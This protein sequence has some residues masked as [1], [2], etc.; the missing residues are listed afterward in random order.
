VTDAT[1]TLDATPAAPDFAGPSA[2]RSAASPR[3]AVWTGVGSG[4]A[5]FVFLLFG[6]TR[7]YDI[8]DSLTIGVFVA[9][10]SISDAFTQAYVLN[11]HV[12]FSFLEHLVYT[13]TG[14]QSEPV[15]RM[16]PIVFAAVSVGVLASLLSRRWGVVA[17]VSGAVL[18]ATNPTFADV[19]SQVRGYSLLMLCTIVST[20]LVIR[21]VRQGGAST[22]I[23][24]VYALVIA[25]GVAT[26][27]YMLV[28][29][30]IHGL[31]TLADRRVTRSWIVPWLGGIV[32]G[33]AA[34]VRVWRPMRQTA[35]ELGRNFRPVFPRDLGYA[36]LGG[37][38]LAVILVAILVLPPLW[39][40]RRDRLVQL[41]ALA[42]LLA[43]G[44]IWIIGPF[45]LYPRFFLWLL[46]LTA[47]GAAAA[48]GRRPLLVLL[49]GAIVV[50]QLFSSWP[51]LTQD[52][53]ASATVARV[54]DRVDQAG[55]RPCT[56]D[57]FASI[58]LLGYRNEF[59]L[60]STRGQMGHCTVA[61]LLGAAPHS[62]LARDANATF[63]YRTVLKARRNGTLWS[64]V[65]PRC[66]LRSPPPA[67]AACVVVPDPDPAPG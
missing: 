45:D 15:M 67:D 62:K 44:G 53:I 21:A 48:V 51:R 49:V 2:R 43:V 36:L 47:L 18:M 5:T 17:A 20:A 6:A 28:V 66:W 23:R 33:S 64:T 27:L 25:V 19:G 56:I 10:P 46:P 50:V 39:N 42:V 8:D 11:N 34:Y 1:V 54:F 30:A 65:P 60:A 24:L 16:L 59:S 38:L 61:V 31:L 37:S 13:S 3:A 22:G 32:I 41:G 14:S 12:F 57:T 29:V 58:R 9:T 26:H 7:A 40:A 63:R 52:Y 55:G 35:D 4:L